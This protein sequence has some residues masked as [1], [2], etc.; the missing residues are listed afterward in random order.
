VREGRAVRSAV[1]ID[2]STAVC[3][4]IGGGS[5]EVI[6]GTAGEIYFTAS[7]PVGAL[8]ISQRFDLTDRPA[9]ERVAA[10]R[11]TV[12]RCVAPLGRRARRIEI[13]LAIGTSGT[14]QALAAICSG[15]GSDMTSNSL[16]PLER[17][18]LE[19]VIGMFSSMTAVERTERFSI[20][21]KR[22][23]TI[24][25]GAIVLS[26]ILGAL[27]IESLLACP[28]AM[29]EGIIESRVASLHT[30]G[31]SGGSLRRRSVR[32]LAERTGC[33]LPHGQ[34]V[35]RL[36]T[37]LF[38]QMRELH[39][40]PAEAR[41]LLEY[42]ALLHE[43]G[44]H[45]SERGHHRHSD[46]LIRHAELKGFTEE[47]LLVIANVA[48]YYRKSP[49]DPSDENLRDLPPALRVTIEKLAALL[50]IAEGLDRGHRQRVRDVAVR[51]KD[52]SLKL[53]A[54]TRTDAS[55]ELQSAEKRARY[56]ARLYGLRVQLEVF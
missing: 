27:R 13:D 32:D 23:A 5:A 25:G 35:S 18:R 17:A 38:D 19:E 53:I 22:A 1:D 34:H 46:Y 40:L 49:P 31:R 56:F 7:E 37:R 2:G 20:D 4:D 50:R 39:E 54:R 14:I 12:A 36:A 51:W 15:G 9:H 41:D 52:G 24:V 42:A 10:C 48:R 11:R 8:R 3:I 30:A 44:A 26:E 28:V 33:D 21:G 16:R 43:S 6:V 45:I 47:Q 29:R 55:V